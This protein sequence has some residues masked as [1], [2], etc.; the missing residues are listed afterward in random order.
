VSGCFSTVAVQISN[1]LIGIA[2]EL[3]KMKPNLNVLAEYRKRENEYLDR[4]KDLET[5]T[6]ERDQAKQQYDDLRK[7]RL[8][9]FMVG[10][11]AISSKLKEMYQVSGFAGQGRSSHIVCND[12]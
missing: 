10:F 4:A 1:G 12:R 11:S 8:E 2:E 3:G 7:T 6:F 5:I 9:E